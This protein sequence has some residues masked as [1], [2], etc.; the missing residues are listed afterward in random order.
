M[1][2]FVVDDYD[3][4]KIADALLARLHLTTFEDRGVVRAWKGRI[5]TRSIACAKRV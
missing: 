4:D 3:A 2:R 1:C 5:R